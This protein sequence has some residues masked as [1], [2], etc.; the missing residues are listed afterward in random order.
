MRSPCHANAIFSVLIHPKSPRFYPGVAGPTLPSIG[1]G[2]T[3]TPESI[4]AP[5][6]EE[7]VS[8][9]N[10]DAQEKKAGENRVATSS[11]STLR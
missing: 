5:A 1:A 9:F 6:G 7:Y 4:E 11:R 8:R 3:S 10:A 2:N